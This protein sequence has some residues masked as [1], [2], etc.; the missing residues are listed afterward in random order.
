MDVLETYLVSL[1][2]KVFKLLPMREA[3]DQGEVN[4]LDE[5]LV[6]LCINCE[7]AFTCH[8]ILSDSA[9]IVE[10]RNNIEFLKNNIDLDFARWRNIVLRS[11]RLTHRAKMRICKGGSKCL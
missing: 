7:G 8:P 1:Q 10:V 6:N 4:H 2:G 11:T 9:D 3:Y 5:Y